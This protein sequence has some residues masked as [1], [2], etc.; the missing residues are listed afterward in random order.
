[1]VWFFSGTS[2]N[3][4]LVEI[5]E[6][7]DHPWFVA[8]QFHPELKSRVQAVHP[9]FHSFVGAAKSYAAVDH[10]PELAAAETPAIEMPAS[11]N[12][13]PL[14]AYA[15]YSEESSAESKSFFPDNG[16]YE[17]ERDLGQ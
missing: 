10:Q 6:I 3:G 9:M 8:V 2:P 1:M 4:E 12:E 11:V 5:I 13:P 16:G 15:G 17:E 14:D 7:K